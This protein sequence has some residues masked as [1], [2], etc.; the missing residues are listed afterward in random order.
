MPPARVLPA[1]REACPPEAP[2]ARPAPV[3]KATSEAVTA[4][5]TVNPIA[6]HLPP[7]GEHR[8]HA[9]DTAA[10]AGAAG[11]VAS[12]TEP[13]IEPTTAVAG[14]AGNVASTEPQVEPPTAVAP[15]KQ[16]SGK[17]EAMEVDAQ[18]D[19]GSLVASTDHLRSHLYLCNKLSLTRRFKNNKKLISEQMDNMLIVINTFHFVGNM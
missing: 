17:Q 2:D 7:A 9:T 1:A 19:S 6:E 8:E 15:A 14:A 18:N 3:D 11:N 16:P 5:Q 10:V 13:Q 4:P 12:T